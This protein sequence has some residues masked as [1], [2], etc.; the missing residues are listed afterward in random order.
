MAININNNNSQQQQHQQQQTRIHYYMSKQ[1]KMLL[2]QYL[3]AKQNMNKEIAHACLMISEMVLL[4]IVLL[5]LVWW[6]CW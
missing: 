4:A 3:H 5:T 1:D 6:C 2:Q